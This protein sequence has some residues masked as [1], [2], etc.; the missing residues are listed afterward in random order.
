MWII[1]GRVRVRCGED[2]FILESG[3]FTL[4]PRGLPHTFL[5]EQDTLMLGLLTPGGTEA[6]FASGPVATTATPPPVDVGSMQRAAEESEC[7]FVGP[8]MTL[9]SD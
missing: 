9:Q 1:S 8:P 7:E 3:G 4:L 2:E 5:S 6:Y